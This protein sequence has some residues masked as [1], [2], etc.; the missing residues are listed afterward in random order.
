MDEFIRSTAAKCLPLFWDLG[1]FL[2]SPHCDIILFR[3]QSKVPESVLL[4]ILKVGFGFNGGGFSFIFSFH[5]YHKV[6]S[7]L[8]VALLQERY[9]VL[10]F[11]GTIL[12]VQNFVTAFNFCIF[13]NYFSY[14]RFWKNSRHILYFIKIAW[15]FSLIILNIIPRY[16][17]LIHFNC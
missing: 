5:N 13:W 15:K 1:C 10:W 8:V 16:S 12:H 7:F 14:D 3:K 11:K 2:Y 6:L 9:V 4:Y 17:F